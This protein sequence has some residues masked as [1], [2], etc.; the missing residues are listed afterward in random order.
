[1]LDWEDLN[2]NNFFCLRIFE[3]KLASGSFIMN[4]FLCNMVLVSKLH[5]FIIYSNAS[6]TSILSYDNDLN[7][8]FGG[9]NFDSLRILE[10]DLT[11]L[12]IVDNG[13]SCF[14]VMS[15]ELSIG[16]YV[17]ELNKEILI[18]LPVIIIIDS[19]VECHGVFTIELYISI[20]SLVVLTGL[21]VAINGRSSDSSGNFLLVYNRNR[22]FS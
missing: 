2:C 16:V 22:K 13:D 1:M 14:S 7:I 3:N 15:N 17:I 8:F 19:N 4:S 6:I 5:G 21:G 20:E 18:G 11:W 12:V 10:S 9:R